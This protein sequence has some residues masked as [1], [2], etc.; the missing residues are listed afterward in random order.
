MADNII[1]SSMT[2]FDDINILPNCGS[3]GIYDIYSPIKV[4]FPSSS[5][6]FK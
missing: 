4:K 5:R 3:R 1:I 2:L 6:H